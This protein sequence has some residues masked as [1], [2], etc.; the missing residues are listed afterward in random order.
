MSSAAVKGNEK[1]L[2]FLTLGFIA[3]GLVMLYSAS[4]AL[5]VAS[6]DD[7]AFFVKRQAIWA[8]FGLSAMVAAWKIDYRKL[9]PFLLP[10]LIL[11]A[12]ALGAVLVPGLGAEV[13]GSKRWMRVA[14]MSVQPS[15]F[16]KVALYAFLAASLA[17][18]QEKLDEFV[19]GLV[20]Y[21]AI[22]GVV[23]TLIIA[24]PDLGTVMAMAAISIGMLYYAGAKLRHLALLVLPA[25]PLLYVQLFMVGFRKGRLMA[26]IDPW[27]DR[28]GAGFQTIQSFLAFSAGG[29]TGKGLGGGTQKLLF[30]PEPHSDFIYSVIGEELGLIG[31]MAVLGAFAI[32]TV[33]GFKVAFGCQDPFG[34][35]L[36][37]G[38]TLMIGFQAFVNM[39]VTTGLIP[40]SGMPLPFISA[41]G[42][43]LLTTLVSVGL[44]MSVA[45]VSRDDPPFCPIDAQSH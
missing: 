1:V 24:E 25:L 20:P 8:V 37:F 33:C 31:T 40:N 42:S 9:R 43:A 19:N 36:A 10:G 14:G 30:L 5:A 41:G 12:L 4:S 44:V 2:L 29:V 17:K 15:E 35:L 7:A 27:S 18:R 23:L 26:Y 34:R 3:F 45:R 11:S 39:S 21:L 28:F 38:L 22:I 16:A 32:F 6:R 13:N